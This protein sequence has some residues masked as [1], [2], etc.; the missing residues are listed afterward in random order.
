MKVYRPAPPPLPGVVEPAPPVPL[1]PVPPVLEPAPP[2]PPPIVAPAGTALP[3]AGQAHSGGAGLDHLRVLLQIRQLLLCELLDLLVLT[4]LCG[5]L[6]AGDVLGM[7]RLH[8]GD[9][10]LVEL[11]GRQGRH[12][13]DL[14][15]LH[16]RQTLG[17]VQL[18][19]L[20]SLLQLLVHLLM[21]VGDVLR[22][23]LD[24][25]ILGLLLNLLAE[26]HLGHAVDGGV[27][28]EQLVAGS[29]GVLADLVELIGDLLIDLLAL[30]SARR[31]CATRACRRSSGCIIVCA[32]CLSEGNASQCHAGRQC[33]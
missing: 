8:V 21:V 14:L 32:A 26:L 1:P 7:H 18:Q 31:A 15:L 4:Q 29:L 19:F 30:L 12:D 33:Q 9:V 27:E 22:Q 20:G 24:V 11:V 5:R 13:L 2:V 28:E 23:F 25:L 16:L 6:E 17:N 3:P 10:L